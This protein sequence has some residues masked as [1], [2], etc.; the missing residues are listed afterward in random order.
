[1]RIRFITLTL[2]VLVLAANVALALDFLV[3]LLM[4]GTHQKP[5]SKWESSVIYQPSSEFLLIHPLQ[6]QVSKMGTSS[7]K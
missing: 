5:P 2:S 1:M 3:Q 4:T 6:K 7:W